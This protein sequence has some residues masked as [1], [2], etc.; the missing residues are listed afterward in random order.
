MRIDLAVLVVIGFFGALGLWSGAIKQVAH[1]AGL[2]AA[3]LG[4]RPL[5]QIAGPIA[6]AKVGWPPLV[7]TI[8]CSVA[9]FFII[10][11]AVVLVLRFILARLLPSGEHGMANRLGGLALGAAKASLVIFAILSALVLFEKPIGNLWSGYKKEADPSTAVGIAR[12]YGLFA[13]MPAVGGLEKIIA[14]ARDPASAA[15]L[16]SDADFQALAQDPRVKAMVDD[17]GI[18]HALQEGNYAELL[19]SVH[20]LEVLNDP[21]LFERLARFNRK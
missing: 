2:V 3:F 21:K 10:Y 8:A 14:A 7:T 15:K 18:R 19:G 17:A 20:V 4:A 16:A 11:I 5:G 12:R 13:S 1:L 6:A 9:G